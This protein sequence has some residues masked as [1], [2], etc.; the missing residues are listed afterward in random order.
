MIEESPKQKEM[1]TERWAKNDKPG[2]FNYNAS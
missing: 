2:P 1:E